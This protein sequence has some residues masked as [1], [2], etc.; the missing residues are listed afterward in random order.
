MNLSL[1][2]AKNNL[3]SSRVT[4]RCYIVWFH[5]AAGSRHTHNSQRFYRNT[6]FI[7]S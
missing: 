1:Y 4:A 2:P 7:I 3:A 5:A 6:V